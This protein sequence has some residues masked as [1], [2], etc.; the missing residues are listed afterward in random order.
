MANLTFNTNQTNSEITF[1]IKAD[2]YLKTGKN[3]S[4][5]MKTYGNSQNIPNTLENRNRLYKIITYTENSLIKKGLL[6]RIFAHFDGTYKALGK[7]RQ[8]YLQSLYASGPSHFFS[9]NKP[10]DSQKIRDFRGVYNKILGSFISSGIFS[11]QDFEAL[12]SQYKNL[13][14]DLSIDQKEDLKS[15]I[16]NGRIILRNQYGLSRSKNL[17]YYF[18]KYQKKEISYE[19]FLNHALLKSEDANIQDFQNAYNAALL[20]FINSGPSLETMQTALDDLE[21]LKTALLTKRPELSFEEQQQLEGLLQQLQSLVQYKAQQQHP[22]LRKKFKNF[23]M[24]REDYAAYLKGKTSFQAIFDQRIQQQKISSPTDLALLKAAISAEK[25][26]LSQEG[27]WFQ[28]KE[29]LKG[30]YEALKKASHPQQHYGYAVWT[31]Y[32]FSY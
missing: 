16:E 13:K 12:E 11:L 19:K 27:I 18:K 17:V 8:A 3:L 1:I 9:C 5:V 26:R 2:E 10:E 30:S 32:Q 23:D 14:K 25:Q 15:L 7:A 6:A 4:E 24:L 20:R 29:T 31:N 21:K 22:F 28:I